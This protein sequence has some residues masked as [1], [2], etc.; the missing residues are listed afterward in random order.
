MYDFILIFRSY[1]NCKQVQAMIVR[2]FKKA[3]LY[4]LCTKQTLFSDLLLMLWRRS[5]KADVLSIGVSSRKLKSK[6]SYKWSWSTTRVTPGG[7]T[8]SIQIFVLTRRSGSGSKSW[9]LQPPLMVPFPWSVVQE[10]QGYT[11]W[12]R[13]WAADR[14]WSGGLSSGRRSPFKKSEALIKQDNVSYSHVCLESLKVVRR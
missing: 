6:L 2:S 13:H 5:L 14:V 1:N 4:A 9:L 11:S 7:T 8:L 10:S 12:P 3:Y